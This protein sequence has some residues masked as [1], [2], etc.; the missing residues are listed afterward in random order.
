MNAPRIL[1]TGGA[2][3]I[4]SHTAKL[5]RLEGI[6]PVVYDNLSTGNRSAVRWGPFVQG[7]ILDTARLVEVMEQYQPA[8]IIHFAASA[9]VGESVAD[10]AKYYNN[11]V[12]GTL[13]L[14]DAC[15]QTGLDKI[16]F[17]SSCATYG[18]PAVLPID[19][20]T[21]QAPIN[22]YGKTKLM[23]ENML[24]DYAAAFGLN[25]VSLRYFNACGADPEGD[26]GEWHDPET[27]LIPRALMA[28][29]GKIPHLEI[30]GDD[31]DTSD[32]T[33]VRDYIHVAD[34]ARA[35]ALAYRH[36]A[37]G[38]ANLALNL[39]TGRGCSIK[40]V[41]QA[42]SEVTGHDVPVMF[43]RRRCGDPPALYADAALAHRTLGFL[44][45]YSDLETI[46]RTAAPFFGLEARP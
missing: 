19:E 6:E 10:P 31:Y 13:S 15:R 27:H 40:E 11:N 36:L 33:C 7:D 8:A 21:P 44:P 34:L 17:S 29:A 20:A 32:G 1:V 30:F 35:H 42:I 26:L 18:V 4:G 24:A 5:L 25:Y 2:G 16:I 43:R 9:Y 45:R 37:S 46:V 28:A 23:A 14:L 39:G 38:G 41:L 12:R 22:P 3:Y